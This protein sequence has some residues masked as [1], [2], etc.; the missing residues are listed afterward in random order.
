MT[1]SAAPQKRIEYDWGR[2][3]M[4]VPSYDPYRDS[5]GYHFDE[6]KARKVLS[7]F[8]GHNGCL[9][10]VKGQQAGKR[11]V[12]EDWQRAIIANLFGWVD[13]DGNRRYREAM[14]FIPRKNGK[15][16]IA[17]GLVLVGLLVDGEPGAEIYGAAAEYRQACLVFEQAYGMV[18]NEERLR[19]RTKRFNGQ[20]KALTTLDG[21][22]AYRPVSADVKSKWGFNTHMAVVDELHALPDSGLVNALSTSLA[23][24]DRRQPL[25]IYIT[26]A[27]WDRPGS[28]CNEKYDYA[29]KVRDGSVRDPQFLPVIYEAGKDDDWTAESTWEKANPN[30]DVSVSRDYLRRECEK[31]KQSPV[32]E[33]AFRRFHLNQRTRT[34]EIWIRVADWDACADATLEEASLV[35]KPCWAGLDLSTSVDFT[36]L[37]LAFPDGRMI[38][39]LWI[40]ADVM[41]RRERTERTL[42]ADWAARGHISLIPGNMIDQEV[43]YADIIALWQRYPIRAIGIDPWNGAAMMTRLAAAGLKVEQFRQGFASMSAPS[44]A[45]EARV[46]QRR[47]KHGG[48]PVMRWMIGNTLVDMDP[49]GNIKPNKGRSADRIDGVVAAIM[50]FGLMDADPTAGGSVYER[51]GLLVI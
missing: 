29:C 10:H 40:P 20:A 26:T 4:L 31:A 30:I 2:L 7:F 17:G 37:V 28:P 25:L 11:L 24:K 49:A 21:R 27:D 13:A 41:D 47:I 51:G 3:L 35:G 15:S 39:R 6:G 19:S 34:S 44:K 33:A 16:T 9:T 14:I 1:I 8:E 22:S 5:A 23:S 43:L 36:A 32:L 48:D 18:L 42:Y 46:L 45:F 50:A 12:L 38:R